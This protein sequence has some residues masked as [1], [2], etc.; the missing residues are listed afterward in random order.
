[1]GSRVGIPTSGYDDGGRRDPFASLV[2]TRRPTATVTLPN[3]RPRRGLAA[4]ALADVT[5]RGIVRNGSK[6]LAIIEGP[7]RQ[8]Y[9][10]RQSDQLLD[11]TIESIDASGVVFAELVDGGMPP[12]HVRKS[13]RAAGEELR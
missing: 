8:S 3:G 12:S 4:M 1:M 2:Q 9:V 10:A 7:N 13:L 11:A 5:V 6:M